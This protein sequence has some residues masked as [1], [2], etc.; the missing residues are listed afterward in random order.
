M[1]ILE[2]KGV[3]KAFGGLAAVSG[4]SFH[5]DAGEIVGLIGP[6]G[7]GKTT[8]FNLVSGVYRPTHGRIIFKDQDITHLKTHAIAR[9]GL[10][11]SFQSNLL[12]SSMTVFANVELACFQCSAKGALGVL[13][14][15]SLRRRESDVTEEVMEV[16][17]FVGLEKMAGW[18]VRQLPHGPQRLVGIA[19]ALATKPELLLLD[20]PVCGMN[21]EETEEVMGLIRSLR[22]RGIVS[23]V[24]EH[25]MRAVM[26]TCDRL[27]VLDHGTK[28]AEGLPEEI[29]QNR[30]VIK[31]YLGE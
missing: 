4:V 17:R 27:I 15:V 29:K 20:E 13:P 16:L 10:V 30:D 23:L 28:I 22:Q 31:A 6:N 7:A 24:V 18:P 1:R 26:S 14:T 21:A 5:I 12:F 19:I 8:M 3:S 11:R 9:K 25:N 2:V